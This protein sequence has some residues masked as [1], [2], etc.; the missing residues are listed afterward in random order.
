MFSFRRVVENSNWES[1]LP[2]NFFRMLHITP[3][4]TVKL[5]FDIL[6]G[7]TVSNVPLIIAIEFAILLGFDGQLKQESILE[8][9]LFTSIVE[10]MKKTQ[11]TKIENALVWLY[12]KSWNQFGQHLIDE[13]NLW[14]FGGEDLEAA[15][16]AVT[17]ARQKGTTE[18]TKELKKLIMD[19]FDDNMAFVK[20]SQ[21]IHREVIWFS[22]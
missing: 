12:V 4:R 6:H 8:M 22:P 21:D 17:Y 14:N 3:S 11:M 19:R 9:E 20:W 1:I 10:Q 16:T 5:F 13:K 15:I 18:L 7:I 2:F